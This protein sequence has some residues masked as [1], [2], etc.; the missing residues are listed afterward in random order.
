M[1]T[2]RCVLGQKLILELVSYVTDNNLVETDHLGCPTWV[3][4]SEMFQK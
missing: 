1:G 3:S 2:V 4:E